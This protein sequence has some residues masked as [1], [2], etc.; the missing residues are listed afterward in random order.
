MPPCHHIARL[1]YQLTEPGQAIANAT[2]PT[3]LEPQPPAGLCGAHLPRLSLMLSSPAWI[4]LTMSMTMTNR[5]ILMIAKLG[6]A[7]VQGTGCQCG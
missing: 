5:M 2:P 7:Q 1:Y 3:L 4:K 6:E